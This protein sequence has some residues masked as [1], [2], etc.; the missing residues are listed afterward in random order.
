MSYFQGNDTSLKECF[1]S[2]EELKR[3]QQTLEE[4]LIKIYVY[5]QELQIAR[6]KSKSDN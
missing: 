5:K 2:V 1:L 6:L 3:S 4:N